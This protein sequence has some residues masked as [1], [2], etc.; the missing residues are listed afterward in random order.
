[1]WARLS[2]PGRWLRQEGLNALARARRVYEGRGGYQGSAPPGDQALN[3]ARRAVTRPE[4]A[5]GTP[6]TWS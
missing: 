5:A 4:P 6:A 3:R 2:G 1:M